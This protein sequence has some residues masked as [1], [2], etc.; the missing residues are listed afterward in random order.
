[1][2]PSAIGSS[3]A[4]NTQLYLFV[5]TEE[6]WR[7][8]RGLPVLRRKNETRIFYC[9]L[10]SDSLAIHCSLIAS[11]LVALLSPPTLPSQ[12]TAEDA[13]HPL[14][15]SYLG[16]TYLSGIILVTTEP[17]PPSTTS[18]MQGPLAFEVKER[19]RGKHSKMA[20]ACCHLCLSQKAGLTPLLSMPSTCPPF[21]RPQL[22]LLQ[23]FPALS[24][25]LPIPRL[26]IALHS[27]ETKST[28]HVQMADWG[29]FTWQ[30]PENGVSPS[31]MLWHTVPRCQQHTCGGRMMDGNLRD[32]KSHNKYSCSDTKSSCM[33]C[34]PAWFKYNLNCAMLSQLLRR[35]IFGGGG[36]LLP[37]AIPKQGK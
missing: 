10:W 31:A 27:W 9:S 1:M 35:R 28:L 2:L 21:P 29:F 6:L 30:H 11:G 8:G 37:K 19:E 4:G 3:A 34:S 17:C 26:A 18:V 13:E 5:L 16:P 15:M 14:P 25:C 23:L 20:N 24:A 7:P 32:L 36:G 12:P 33:L 22:Q